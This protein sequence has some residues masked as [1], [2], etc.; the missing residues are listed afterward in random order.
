MSSM[1]RTGVHNALT[2]APE[3]I[4]YCRGEKIRVPKSMSRVNGEGEADDGNTSLGLDS[5]YGQTMVRWPYESEGE[6]P[7]Q[8]TRIFEQTRA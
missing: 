4:A 6:W 3:R 7:Y 1:F 8:S 5:T 2:E